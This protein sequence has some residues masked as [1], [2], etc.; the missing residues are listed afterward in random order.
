MIR[1]IKVGLEP[2]HVVPSWD[3]KTLWVN[4]NRDS[5]TPI[6]PTTGDRGG[7]DI[8]VVDPYNLYFTPDGTSAMVMAEANTDIDFRDPHT[9][10]LQSRLHL[11]DACMGVN[12]ADFSADGSYMIASCEFSGRIVKID[13]KSRTLVGY[14]SLGPNTSPQDVKVDPYGRSSTSPT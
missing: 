6:D 1:T 4:N 5:L 7:P 2:Q 8:P 14:L 9:F 10:V 3:L 13:L 12:H 11:G